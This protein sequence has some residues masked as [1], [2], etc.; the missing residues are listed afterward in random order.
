MGLIVD[1][2]VGWSVGWL[3]GRLVGLDGLFVGCFWFVCLLSGW[4][5]LL[6]GWLICWLGMF[7]FL[8]GWMDVWVDGWLVCSMVRW[9][10]CLLVAW[11]V[12]WL[13]GRDF[14][15]LVVLLICVKKFV[16]KTTC[17][18]FNL[19]RVD[20]SEILCFVQLGT[21]SVVS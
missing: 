13:H 4:F 6:V 5:A 12:C 11:L 20:I 10:V 7:S 3:V 2:F 17:T 14:G 8:L 15:W 16:K 21:Q 19:V 1:W 18:V 9:F